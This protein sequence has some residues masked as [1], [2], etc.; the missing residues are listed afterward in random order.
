CASNVVVAPSSG[1]EDITCVVRR[2]AARLVLSRTE[3]MA[4][5]PF[6]SRREI[7]CPALD[8]ARSQAVKLRL[9]RAELDEASGGDRLIEGAKTCHHALDR[10]MAAAGALLAIQT[11]ARKGG[12]GVDLEYLDAAVHDRIVHATEIGLC[13]REDR[14][15]LLRV[16]IAENVLLFLPDH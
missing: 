13:E 15:K 11:H 12:V 10:V 1:A 9:R 5:P 8:R 3:K 7:A 6:Q 4:Q 16:R 2:K 14:A